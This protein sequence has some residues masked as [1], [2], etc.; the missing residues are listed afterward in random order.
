MTTAISFA[1]IT[2]LLYIKWRS[3]GS[4]LVFFPLTSVIR[5]GRVFP[6]CSDTNPFGVSVSIRSFW[7][8]SSTETCF[9]WSGN[10]SVF[11]LLFWDIGEDPECWT[12][13]WKSSGLWV[14]F[15]FLWLIK[16]NLLIEMNFILFLSCEFNLLKTGVLS[17]FKI[18]LILSLLW[19][20]Y[21]TSG[22]IFVNGWVC[23]NESNSFTHWLAS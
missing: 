19:G 5:L 4:V 21:L 8:K 13:N 17:L 6:L 20:K 16:W 23:H 14:W 10:T 2:Q 7:D 22:L 12:G 9:L 15:L 11:W 18:L 1:V 3:Q